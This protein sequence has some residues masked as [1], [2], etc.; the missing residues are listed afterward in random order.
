MA[1][2]SHSPTTLSLTFASGV[3]QCSFVGG[4]VG[5][6]GGSD[7]NGGGSDGGGGDSGGGG[8]AGGGGA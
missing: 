5:D 8:G 6:G 3:P 2:H 4:G 1:Y 7:G